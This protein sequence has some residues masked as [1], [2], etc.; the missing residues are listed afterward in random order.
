MILFYSATGN[1]A[2]VARRIA[3]TTGDDVLDLLPTLRSNDSLE[4]ESESPWVICAPTYAWRIPRMVEDLLRHARL[5]GSP[6]VY[7]VMTCGGNIGNAGAYLRKLC[8]ECGWTYRGCTEVVMPENYSLLFETP[9]QEK[10]RKVIEAASASIDAAASCIAAR[11]SLPTRAVGLGDRISSGPVNA[12]F[13]PLLVH[14]RKFFCTDAC[15]GCGACVSV[16]PLNN[17]R[18]EGGRPVWGGSCTHCTAC[19]NRCPKAAIEYGKGTAR[20]LRYTCPTDMD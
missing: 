16:C 1:S 8:E 7:F 13:Y 9:T 3:K 17:I 18:L 6:D 19:I 5:S 11:K 14:D 12:L 15:V 20:K 4:L 2:Y 10:A